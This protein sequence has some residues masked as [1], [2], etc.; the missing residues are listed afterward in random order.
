ML[1]ENP[2]VPGLQLPVAQRHEGV[3]LVH[4]VAHVPVHRRRLLRARR[5][6]LRVAQAEVPMPYAKSLERAALTGATPLLNVIHET[7]DAV[8]FRR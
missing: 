6:L 1:S 7:L 4:R 8:N 3:R 2:V 5:T